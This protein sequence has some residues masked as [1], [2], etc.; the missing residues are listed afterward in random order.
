V[1]VFGTDHDE[2]A[3]TVAR[4]ARYPTQAALGLHPTLR[5][6]YTFDE[7]DSI[8]MA[9]SLRES[10]VFSPHKLAQSPPFSRM[11][12]IVCHR[13]FEGVSST[14]RADIVDALHFALRD[15]GELVAL[16]HSHYFH[17][18]RFELTPEG[19][20]RRRPVN[21]RAQRSG[22][23]RSQ[24]EPG[25]EPISIGETSCSVQDL[26]AVVASLPAGVSIHDEHGI[27]RH[28]GP[29]ACHGSS[30]LGNSAK[31]ALGRLYSEAMPSWIA[32]VLQTGEPVHDLELSV[33]DSGKARFWI[34]QLAPIR[35]LDGSVTGVTSAVHDITS[36]KQGAG[37]R[38]DDY[39][40]TPRPEV[41]S[42][43]LE[44]HIEELRGLE[45]SARAGTGL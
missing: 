44:S 26:E 33:Y 24:R 45:P 23:P 25:V 30:A 19:H 36:L 32:R 43:A 3:L 11:D 37:E 22:R 15:E 10:C 8:R 16:D 7:D 12:M 31:G 40:E 27:V 28:G 34:C 35:S 1:Q 20:L 13:V 6:R 4:A 2:E 42:S 14:R 38:H 39:R 18:D 29:G 17:D 9:E 5:A 41:D 21:A